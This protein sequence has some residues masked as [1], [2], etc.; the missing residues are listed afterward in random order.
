MSKQ[1]EAMPP[2]DARSSPTCRLVTTVDGG[3]GLR[4]ASSVKHTPE[5]SLLD[6][7]FVVCMPSSYI[8]VTIKQRYIAG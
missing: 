8:W 3:Q 7:F 4:G 2:R 1:A 6:F 5:D